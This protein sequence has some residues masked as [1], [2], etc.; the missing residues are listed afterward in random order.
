VIRSLSNVSL[1][2]PHVPLG[3]DLREGL[4]LLQGLQVA[5]VEKVEPE[6][7]FRADAPSFSVAI[8]PEADRVRSVWYDDHAGRETDAANYKKILAYLAR[9][10]AIENW[11]MRKGNGWMRYWLNPLDQVAMVYGVHR[12]VMRFNQHRGS[13]RN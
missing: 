2:T 3:I 5:V 10:G 13:S 11:E 7:C 4:R 8:Y 6:R 9:Y 12:D 1:R